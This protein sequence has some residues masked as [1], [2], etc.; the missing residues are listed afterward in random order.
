MQASRKREIRCKNSRVLHHSVRMNLTLTPEQAQIIQAQIQSGR[1]TNPE[2]A[3]ELA[4]R[5]LERSNENYAEWVEETRQKIQVAIEQIDR[6]EVL[7]RETVVAQLQEKLRTARET[8]ECP[9]S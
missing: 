8:K 1:F 9:N 6:G 5:L 7:D 2:E 4:L 3:I